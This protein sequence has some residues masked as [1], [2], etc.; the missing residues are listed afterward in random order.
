MVCLSFVLVLVSLVVC[1][2]V[3]LLA[4]VAVGC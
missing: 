3:L 4:S 1:L 2:R